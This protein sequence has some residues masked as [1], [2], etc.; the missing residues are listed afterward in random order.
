MSGKRYVFEIIKIMSLMYFIIIGI[1]QNFTSKLPEIAFQGLQVLKFFRE[2]MPGP[3]SRS[4]A[5]GFRFDIPKIWPWLSM[6][7]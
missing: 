7:L 1:L 6:S 3:P 5:F 4:H 2:N